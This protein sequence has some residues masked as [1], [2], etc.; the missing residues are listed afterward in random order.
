MPALSGHALHRYIPGHGPKFGETQ[1]AS[2][3]AELHPI[4]DLYIIYY[5]YVYENDKYV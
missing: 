3:L 1:E 4:I 5:S 2:C